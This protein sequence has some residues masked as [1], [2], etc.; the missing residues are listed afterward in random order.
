MMESIR[1][2]KQKVGVVGIYL[3][4]KKYVIVVFIS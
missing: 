2:G 4:K 1:E 3:E